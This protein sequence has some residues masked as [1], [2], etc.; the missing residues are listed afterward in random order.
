MKYRNIVFDVGEVLLS[1]R[2]REMMVDYG[3]SLDEAEAFYH[4]MFDDPL[5][6]EF[7]LENLPYDEVA[8]KY[9]E[10]YP[11]QSDAIHY[12]LY[13]RELM[14]VAREGVYARIEQLFEQGRKIF[15]LSNYSSE[16]FAIHT[17]LIPF[18]DRISGRMVS[19][20]I[21]ICKPDR[22]IYEAL[23]NKY[24]IRPG[25]SLFFDDRPENVDGAIATGMDAVYVTSEKMLE[26]RL[27]ELIKNV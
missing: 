7:D 24:D 17:A 18:M 5:W 20:M 6:T 10:K 9:I 16:L 15:L 25:E 11:S 8:A 27:D 13:H 22:R 19:S 26:Q 14:P 3:L 4:L 1:Y 12:F 21:H 23:Y 2:W